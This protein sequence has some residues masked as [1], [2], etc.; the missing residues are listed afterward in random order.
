MPRFFNRRSRIQCHGKGD[1]PRGG[2]V[3][4][5]QNAAIADTGH[6]TKMTVGQAGGRE[7][8]GEQGEV[9]PS[10]LSTS[11]NHQSSISSIECSARPL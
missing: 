2:E 1:A 6:D 8:Q 10:S 7:G 3:T 11:Y 9:R 5:Q 4:V